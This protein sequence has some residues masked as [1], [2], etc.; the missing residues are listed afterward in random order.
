MQK[1]LIIAIDALVLLYCVNFV[2]TKNYLD[3]YV[4]SVFLGWPLIRWIIFSRPV[5]FTFKKQESDDG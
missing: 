1:R 4:V 3:I 2:M 5:F